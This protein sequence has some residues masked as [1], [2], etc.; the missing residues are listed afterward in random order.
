MGFIFKVQGFDKDRTSRVV[1]DRKVDN[2]LSTPRNTSVHQRPLINDSTWV[3]NNISAPRLSVD[4]LAPRFQCKDAFT[5]C[6]KCKSVDA[7]VPPYRNVDDLAPSYRRVEVFAQIVSTQTPFIHRSVDISAPVQ[8]SVDATA[9]GYYSV[10]TTAPVQDSV[11]ATAPGYYSVDAYCLAPECSFP[12]FSVEAPAPDSTVPDFSVAAPA[13][14]IY[15]V[16]ANQYKNSAPLYS[17]VDVTSP[18]KYAPSANIVESNVYD[19]K[20]NDGEFDWG[21]VNYGVHLAYSQI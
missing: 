17:S 4:A 20:S 12:D 7:L 15:S 19:N 16:E 14:H 21:F 11:D 2:V 3:N 6:F 1:G 18:R 9:P 10:D 8:D 5:S 13:P